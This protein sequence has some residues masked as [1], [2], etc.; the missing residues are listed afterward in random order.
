M[1]VAVA[2]VGPGPTVSPP[3]SGRLQRQ[4]ARVAI[5]LRV[6]AG[7]LHPLVKAFACPQAH[8]VEGTAGVTAV[9]D[10]V[11][12][13]RADDLRFVGRRPTWNFLGRDQV[14]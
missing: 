4:P 3:Q 14:R 9:R 7:K 1:L 13:L 11:L 12:G 10:R 5:I 8:V 2:G 6:A